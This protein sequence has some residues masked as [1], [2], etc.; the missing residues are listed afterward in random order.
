MQPN[1]KILCVDDDSE[2]R[3]IVKA[4]LPPGVD[5]DEASNV[6]EAIHKLQMFSYGII[7]IDLNLGKG[8]SGFQLI[9]FIK[10]KEFR[11]MPYVMII[12]GSEKEDDEIRGHQLEVTEYIKKPLR[13][14]VFKALI[15]K[16]M[17]K[18]SLNGGT[19]KKVGPLKV[20]QQ[21]M[22]VRIE[23][24]DKDD[25]LYL[26][27][28]EYKLLMKFMDSPG[29]A[30]TREQLY[31]EVWDASSEIQSRTIDMHVSALRKKLGSFGSSISS[32]RGVG[33]SF[34]PTRVA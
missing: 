9:E 24:G 23:N 19:V 34:D 22:Q 21:K 31:V 10:E 14:P 16:Y 12:T 13:V 28:K 18:F 33:Y 7:M 15:S 20:D 26:T 5:F 32:V 27:L 11:T 4:S 6:G 8:E 3:E 2:M 25:D 17:M 1:I 30:Y 29:I